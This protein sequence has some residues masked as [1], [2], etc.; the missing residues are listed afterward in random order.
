M[1]DFCNIVTEIF[2]DMNF[3]T[4]WI[5]P[6]YQSKPAIDLISVSSFGP[7][8]SLAVNFAIYVGLASYEWHP[9]VAKLAAS[10]RFLC[11]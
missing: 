1:V 3:F 10:Q 6:T 11:L 2:R 7:A 8:T 5:F 9:Y 4:T